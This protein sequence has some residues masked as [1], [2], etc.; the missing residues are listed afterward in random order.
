MCGADTLRY[1]IDVLRSVVEIFSK[2]RYS[3]MYSTHM[4]GYGTGVLRYVVQILRCVLQ[5]LR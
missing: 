1:S 3:E 5:I 2:Y 4:L